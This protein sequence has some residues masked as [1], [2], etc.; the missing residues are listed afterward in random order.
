[1]NYALVIIVIQQKHC[2]YLATSRESE[3]NRQ[4]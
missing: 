1:M 4:S 2:D 3:E